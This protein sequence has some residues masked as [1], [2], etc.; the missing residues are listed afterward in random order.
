LIDGASTAK[1]SGEMLV[2]L[3]MEKRS[4]MGTGLHIEF[5]GNEI[6]SSRL[7]HDEKIQD[8]LIDWVQT[9]TN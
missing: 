9:I 4:P 8:A 2:Q 6:P 1:R 7:S 3:L 5:T